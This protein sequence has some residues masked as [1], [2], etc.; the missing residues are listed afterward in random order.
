MLSTSLKSVVKF[1]ITN[2]LKFL[3]TGWQNNDFEQTISNALFYPWTSTYLFP[4]GLTGVGWRK[5]GKEKTA[6][7]YQKQFKKFKWLSN[8]YY[9]ARAPETS[10]I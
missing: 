1:K 3:A 4:I 5:F 2:T 8:D 9:W 10:S 6:L 7:D